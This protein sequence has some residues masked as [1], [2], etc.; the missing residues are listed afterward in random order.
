MV[1]EDTMKYWKFVY[2]TGMS[3]DEN[4]LQ[5]VAY[6]MA[7]N[8]VTD[9]TFTDINDEHICFNGTYHYDDEIPFSGE[10][11]LS[12]TGNAICNIIFLSNKTNIEINQ[13]LVQRYENFFND[14]IVGLRTDHLK[15]N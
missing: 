1:M 13:K 6:Q 10:I 9:V 5:V 8:K 3:N 2:L 4:V 14:D 7:G 11:Y 12:F 15:T